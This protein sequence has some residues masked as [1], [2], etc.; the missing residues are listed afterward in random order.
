MRYYL[1]TQPQRG[2]NPEVHA[3]GCRYMP[4]QQARS[5]LGDFP[6]CGPAVRL[7]RTRYTT[8]D[9]CYWCARAC[10]IR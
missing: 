5:Y 2:Q 7:A 6:N 4:G 9:G 8:A 10:H 1:N 3:E